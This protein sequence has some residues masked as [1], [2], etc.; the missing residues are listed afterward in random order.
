MCGTGHIHAR[1][2]VPVGGRSSDVLRGTLETLGIESSF[3]EQ[4][5]ITFHNHLNI[6]NAGHFADMS[7]G[8]LELDAERS[9]H[10][11][12]LL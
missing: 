5:S 7:A 6:P 8:K 2:G 3:W 12:D 1:D 4:G 10:E 9:Q 11:L